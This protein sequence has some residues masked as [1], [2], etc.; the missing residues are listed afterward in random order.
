MYSY[1]PRIWPSKNR[2]TSSNI[3][4]VLLWT[5]TY[6]QAK[7]GRPARTYI[8]QL[9]KDTGC[10]PEDLPEA[11]NDRGKWRERVR[12][13]CASGMTWWMNDWYS[14]VWFSRL[15]K[16]KSSLYTYIKYIEFGLV[17][18]YGISTIVGYL[19]PNPLYIYIKYIRLVWLGFMAYQLLW[20]I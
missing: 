18:F 6:G 4:D 20:V 2:T 14:Y 15:F 9:C 17:E 11:M 19:M 1:G 8:Q 5:P 12:D 3:S 13:I 7:T 16:T 10:S